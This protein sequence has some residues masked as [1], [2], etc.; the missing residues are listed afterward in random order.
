MPAL[1]LFCLDMFGDMLWRGADSGGIRIHVD[2]M[3]PFKPVFR[4]LQ[5]RLAILRL[6]VLLLNRYVTRLLFCGDVTVTLIVDR[7]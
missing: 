6:L 4:P 5:T 7:Y 2:A 3:S 1:P